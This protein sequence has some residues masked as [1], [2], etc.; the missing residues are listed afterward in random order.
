MN[1]L[2]ILECEILSGT[3]ILLRSNTCCLGHRIVA[4]DKIL[5][6]LEHLILAK[7]GYCFLHIQ[8]LD[9]TV[10]PLKLVC[11]IRTIRL[12]KI[13]GT[14]ILFNRSGRNSCLWLLYLL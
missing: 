5:V 2:Q 6:L 4:S 10:T 13:I 11:R 8:I 9:I 7:I 12:C 1:T 3:Q 14:E